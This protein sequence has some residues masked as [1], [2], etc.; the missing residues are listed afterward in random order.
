MLNLP[1]SKGTLRC[2]KTKTV[3]QFQYPGTEKSPSTM[4]NARGKTKEVLRR[5]LKEAREGDARISSG[6][7]FQTVGASKAKL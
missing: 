6:R 2:N 4:E 7:A 3:N 1:Y 5:F